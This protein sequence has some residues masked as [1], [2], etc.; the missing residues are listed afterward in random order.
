MSNHIQTKKLITISMMVLIAATLLVAGTASAQQTAM[1]DNLPAVNAS[2]YAAEPIPLTVDQCGQ[3]HTRHFRDLKQAGGKHQFDCR[4]C[5]E[6]FHAYN[7]PRNNYAEIMPLCA[8]CHGQPHGDKHVECINCH[9][10]PHAPKR[11]PM[12]HMLEGICSDCHGPQAVE[13]QDFPSKHTEQACNSCHHS[14]HGYIPVCAECHEPHFATQA[15]AT[16][17]QCHPVHQP[18]TIALAA[19]VDLQTCD[20]CHADIYA[21]WGGTPS[22]HAEVSCAECHTEHGLIPACSNCH[23]TPATHNEKL[24]AMFPNCLDCHLDVHDLPV[25]K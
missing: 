17:M 16:C 9:E 4:E 1:R 7:P 22:K 19:D 20:A 10:N 23:E 2:L 8:T 13:L 18:R 5:H 11:V 14:R 25:K 6:V 3:C 15:E 24:M 12:T 21:T